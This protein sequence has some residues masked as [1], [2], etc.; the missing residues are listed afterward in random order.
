MA[1]ILRYVLG[2]DMAKTIREDGSLDSSEDF[3]DD[4]ASFRVRR[5]I[6]L[7]ERYGQR[8]IWSKPRSGKEAISHGVIIV[9]IMFGV[10]GAVF[11]SIALGG[12][13]S[14]LLGL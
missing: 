14:C 6:H 2:L 7:Q 5:E 4:G 13:I 3:E 12:I 10:I 9:L 1:E 8:S 11:L